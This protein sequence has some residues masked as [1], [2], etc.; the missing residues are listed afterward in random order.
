MREAWLDYAV[1]ALALPYVIYLIYR[2]IK[3]IRN[4]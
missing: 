2:G 4:A 1:I 3:E